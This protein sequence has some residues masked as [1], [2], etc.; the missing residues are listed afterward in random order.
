MCSSDLEKD[1]VYPLILFVQARE[2]G[3]EHYYGL[4]IILE[5]YPDS[6]LAFLSMAM[7]LKNREFYSA[8]QDIPVFPAQR[9]PEKLLPYLQDIAELKE[10]K[11]VAAF[12]RYWQ[13]L[14]LEKMEKI[15]NALEI[16]RKVVEENQGEPLGKVAHSKIMAL[17]PKRRSL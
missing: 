2:K 9:T 8:H 15:S 17:T 7:Y 12:A 16:Y 10:Y 11:E 14:L 6:P 1:N 4:R 3:A 13:G 5:R